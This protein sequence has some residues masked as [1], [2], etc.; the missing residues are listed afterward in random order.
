MG[1]CSSCMIPA[2]RDPRQF[3]HVIVVAPGDCTVAL[4][5][6]DVVFRQSKGRLAALAVPYVQVALSDYVV[7]VGPV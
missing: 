3:C 1:L 6:F 2:P 7:I 5:A 4:A